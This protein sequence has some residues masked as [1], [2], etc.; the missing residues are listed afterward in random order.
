MGA[1]Y[2]ESN[3]SSGSNKTSIYLIIIQT[4]QEKPS[5]ITYSNVF[6]HVS[7]IP[8][9]V[10]PDKHPVYVSANRQNYIAEL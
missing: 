7:G 6:R 10:L 2:E 3:A 1:S 9:E 4:V 5:F 8:N